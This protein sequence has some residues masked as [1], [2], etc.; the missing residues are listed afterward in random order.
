MARRY[1]LLLLLLNVHHVMSQTRP[2][3][4]VGGSKA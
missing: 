4:D 1:A 3:C 2:G